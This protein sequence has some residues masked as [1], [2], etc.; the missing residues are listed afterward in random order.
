MNSIKTKTS[1][2]H[3]EKIQRVKHTLTPLRKCLRQLR[4]NPLYFILILLI[5]IQNHNLSFIHKNN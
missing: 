2:F 5:L 1:T 4:N 3:T